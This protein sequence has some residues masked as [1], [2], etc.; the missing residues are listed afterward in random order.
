MPFEFNNSP[1]LEYTEYEYLLYYFVTRFKNS[2]L[3]TN[4]L[5]ATSLNKY[6]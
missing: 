1:T 5:I 3:V 4:L 6:V 2:T